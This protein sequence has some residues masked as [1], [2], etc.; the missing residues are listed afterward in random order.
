[1][2][3]V[4]TIKLNLTVK[5]VS[6]LLKALPYVGDREIEEEVDFDE[7]MG[8]KCD[9]LTDKIEKQLNKQKQN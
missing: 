3:T 8:H 4:K 2:K 9:T 7:R 6:L 5:E 1:M